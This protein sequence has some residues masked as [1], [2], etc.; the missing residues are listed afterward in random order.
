M[1][2]PSV[3]RPSKASLP[4]CLAVSLSTGAP[5]RA[6]LPP[7]MCCDSQM[8]SWRRSPWFLLNRR[9]LACSMTSRTSA[10]SPF[11]SAESLL[12][13]L[14]KAADERKLL[15]AMSI[16]SFCRTGQRM[17]KAR[18]CRRRLTDGTLPS[19]KA[20]HGSQSSRTVSTEAV[21][22]L[23]EM[24]PYHCSLRST[25]ACFCLTSVGLLTAEDMMKG[26]VG[27]LGYH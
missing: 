18:H 27:Y 22:D 11:P 13:G 14:L 2:V 17:M 4:C 3:R 19:W 10:T 21:G 24:I 7:S 20:A 25:S 8:K 12:E 5:G 9:T 15:R 1:S 16:C 23:P 6:A 26:E